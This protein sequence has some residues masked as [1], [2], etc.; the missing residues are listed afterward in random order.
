ML[1][2]V[3]FALIQDRASRV[4]VRTAEVMLHF[5]VVNAIH[6]PLSNVITQQKSPLIVQ[7]G[8]FAMFLLWLEM[9]VRHNL[10]LHTLTKLFIF[11]NQNRFAASD[12]TNRGIELL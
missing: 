7:T 8:I 2:R 4:H 5:H 3:K 10:W 1:N 11:K 12:V 6:I 9:N